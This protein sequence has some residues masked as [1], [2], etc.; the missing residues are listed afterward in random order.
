MDLYKI[1]MAD[2]TENVN[3][4]TTDMQVQKLQKI[5]HIKVTIS[6]EITST[7]RSGRVQLVMRL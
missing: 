7:Y 6:S 2:L 4:A 1:V 3:I 5:Y